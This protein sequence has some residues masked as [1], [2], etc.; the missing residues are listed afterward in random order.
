MTELTEAG[1]LIKMTFGKPLYVSQ[2][3][4]PDQVVIKINKDYFLSPNNGRRMLLSKETESQ[5]ILTENIPK[6]LASE[7]EK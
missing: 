7:Q 1:I 6:L 2:G 5:F 3:D 4:I